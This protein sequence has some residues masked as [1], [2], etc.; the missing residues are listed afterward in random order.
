MNP[1][2][3]PSHLF[4]A[5][6]CDTTRPESSTMRFCESLGAQYRRM[7]GT[8]LGRGCANKWE[9]RR[10]SALRPAELERA[11]RLRIE[12]WKFEEI[13]KALCRSVTC[14]RWHIPSKASKKTLHAIIKNN[15]KKP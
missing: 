10:W 14:I 1:L 5:T 12:G 13:A 15:R 3:G 11:V 6:S 8:S 7:C 4:I 2:K 9:A